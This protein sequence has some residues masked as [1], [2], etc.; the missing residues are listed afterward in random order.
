VATLQS[1]PGLK[2]TRTKSALS[3]IHPGGNAPRRVELEAGHQ[4]FGRALDREYWFVM[5]ALPGC[6]LASLMKNAAR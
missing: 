2:R 3:T 6:H 5:E 1:K 4:G